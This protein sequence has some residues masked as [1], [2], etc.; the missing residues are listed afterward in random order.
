[1]A[2]HFHFQVFL[3]TS[4]YSGPKLNS[5]G[6]IMNPLRCLYVCCWTLFVHRCMNKLW[7]RKWDESQKIATC[8]GTD[9]KC[10]TLLMYL[11]DAMECPDYGF[12][13]IMEWARKCFEAGFDFNPR[14]KT[15]FGKFEL[16][17]W[18]YTQCWI[19]VATPG[20]HWS[21]WTSTW[22]DVHECDLLWLCASVTLHFAKQEM[23]AGHNLVL[24]PNN[25]LAR[26]KPSDD[27]RLGEALSGSMYQG[28]TGRVGVHFEA[29]T[30]NGKPIPQGD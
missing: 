6:F 15:R 7:Y 1:M 12:K 22:Y 29:S 9:Q 11:L 18:I 23:M 3:L 14:C 21:S 5:L 24:D 10:V 2:W 28:L 8:R 4:S 30:F 17:V 26:Y 19:D 27:S 25:P 13:S 20:A 16:D